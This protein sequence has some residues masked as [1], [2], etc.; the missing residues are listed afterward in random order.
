[1][2]AEGIKPIASLG[3]GLLGRRAG[4]K[5]RVP[6]SF[7]PP[8]EEVVPGS[9][10]VPE[11]VL[12]MVRLAKALGVDTP[13]G[14]V[15]DLPEV[16]AAIEALPQAAA[17]PVPGIAPAVPG[18]RV[19]FTLRLDADRH[20]RLR[21]QAAAEGRS[22]QHLLSEAFDRYLAQSTGSES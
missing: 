12:R 11:V 2:S 21:A 16:A 17:A 6:L 5:R 7:A 10:D 9:A 14:S 15:D 1:M 4:D 18:R 8:P 3:A 19:A 22:A 13:V 20:A